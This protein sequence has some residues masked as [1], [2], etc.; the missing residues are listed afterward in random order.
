MESIF[1][2]SL[3]ICFCSSSSDLSSSLFSVPLFM[4]ISFSYIAHLKSSEPYIC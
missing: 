3:E 4:G 1:V 2:F